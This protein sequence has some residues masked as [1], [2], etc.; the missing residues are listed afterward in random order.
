M[1]SG[2]ERLLDTLDAACGYDASGA[3]EFFDALHALP[4]ERWV[5]WLD[6]PPARC[7]RSA[8]GDALA[9]RGIHPWLVWRVCDQVATELHRFERSRNLLRA[10]D[11]A[12]LARLTERSALAVV[13]RWR[14]SQGSRPDSGRCAG[15]AP[16][17][18]RLWRGDLLAD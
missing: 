13:A 14:R 2:G 12:R 4:L 16:W 15:S 3:R 7:E 6:N 9:V 11:R 5:A 8:A 17:L 1:F 18:R 10:A